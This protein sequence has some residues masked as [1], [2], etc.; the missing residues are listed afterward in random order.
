VVPHETC[1]NAATAGQRDDVIDVHLESARPNECEGHP[2]L[3]TCPTDAYAA[4][5]THR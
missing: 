3:T 4:A 2:S 1:P 5:L